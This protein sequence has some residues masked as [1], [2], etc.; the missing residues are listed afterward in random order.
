MKRK[1]MSLLLTLFCCSIITFICSSFGPGQVRTE[2]EP[3][4]LCVSSYC[5]PSFNP[6]TNENIY[7]T[8]KFLTEPPWIQCCAQDCPYA[9]WGRS[10]IL[11]TPE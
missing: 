1:T 11:I 6:N 2:S 7:Y 4:E 5:L 9:D 10:N 3:W 8:N